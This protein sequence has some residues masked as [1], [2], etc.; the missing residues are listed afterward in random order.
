MNTVYPYVNKLNE[1]I[2]DLRKFYECKDYFNYEV[3]LRKINNLLYLM[4]D[5]N[6]LTD[7]KMLHDLLQDIQN[8]MCTFSVKSFENL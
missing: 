3:E 6:Y 7:A 2:N 8:D 5:D 1:L 4:L